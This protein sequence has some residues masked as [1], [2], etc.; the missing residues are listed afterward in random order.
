MLLDEKIDSLQKVTKRKITYDEIAKVLGLS[1]KQ[2]AY[3]RVTR[4]QPLKDWEILK[5]EEAFKSP[6]IN[7]DE[8]RQ[9]IKE[10]QEKL[11]ITKSDET[12]SIPYRPDVY[13]S[14]G[15]GVEVY[16]ESAEFVTLDVRLF[17]TDR[18]TKI[19][20]AHCEVVRISGK[21]IEPEYRHGD[22]VII[23]RDDTEFMDGHIFAFRYNGQC[24]VKE[25][26]VMG[27]KIKCISLNKEYEPFYIKEGEEFTVFGRI[28]PRI[29]L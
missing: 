5:L 8:I 22:R 6:P 29:R 3:N 23:D 14:A 13:L 12:V 1:S 17:T 28:L 2:A 11:G 18:G 21:S 9:K 27:N 4:K 16:S 20:P 24:Y 10:L 15:Y 25:I 7:N 26:N 19:N